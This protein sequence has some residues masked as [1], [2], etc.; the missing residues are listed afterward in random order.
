M[1]GVTFGAMLPHGGADEFVGWSP[2]RAWAR[3]RDAAQAFEELGYDSIWDSDHLM[4]SGGDRSG[5]YFEA[6]STLAAV[7]QVTSRVGLG[8]L[9]T[10]ALYRNVA[11]L[12]KAASAVDVMSGGRLIFALGG[13]WDEDECTA[14]GVEFPSAADRVG[15]FAETLEAVL[16]LWDGESVE[17]SGRFVQLRGARCRPVLERRPPVWTGTHGARGLR[18][19]AR[20]ADVANWNVGL[21]EFE[22]LSGVLAAACRT[23]GRDP[24]T[25]DRS[26]FRLVDL[27]DGSSATVRLLAS[28]GAP[29][30]ALEAVR[31]EHFVGSPEEVVPKVQAFVDAGARH[32]VLLFLDAESS[33]ESAS[34]FMREVRPALELG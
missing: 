32:V 6:Y 14:Y 16:R 2:T 7:S 5:P 1:A 19:A 4:A 8:S 28:Q 22:R 26:V 34:R 18:I 30:E 11:M 27:S 12:A 29:P 31:A 25:I 21:G 10:C 20:F 17:F 3:V 9:V 24:A 33:D 15:L 13:G 23:V